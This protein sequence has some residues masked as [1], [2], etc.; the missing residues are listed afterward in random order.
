MLERNFLL[1][2]VSLIE[3]NI[4]F[5][6]DFNKDFK[7]TMTKDEIA[8]MIDAALAGQGTNID[9][10]GKLPV[11]LHAILDLIPDGNNESM[12]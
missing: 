6:R 11:I 1:R 3:N 7:R 8:A 10:S 5:N 4:M 9:A 2:Y 12:G